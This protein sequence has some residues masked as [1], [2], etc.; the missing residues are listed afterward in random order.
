MAN[1]YYLATKTFCLKY[2]PF[3]I[4]Y[5]F[6]ANYLFQIFPISMDGDPQQDDKTDQSN[7]FLLP[8]IIITAIII[9][10]LIIIM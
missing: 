2:Y 5:L 10:L 3:R 4:F 9:I 1:K 8:V 7:I 6:I